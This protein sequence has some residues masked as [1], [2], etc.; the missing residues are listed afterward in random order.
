MVMPAGL[1]DMDQF[2]AW[3]AVYWTLNLKACPTDPLTVWALT[4][5]AVGAGGG[6]M[7]ELHAPVLLPV[8]MQM[9]AFRLG[10]PKPVGMS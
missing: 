3:A 8:T 1:P 9:R 6:V 5:G 10:V 4:V 2:T 7:D